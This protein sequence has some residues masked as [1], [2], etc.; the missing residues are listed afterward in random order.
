MVNYLFKP[1]GA[2]RVNVTFLL[3]KLCYGEVVQLISLDEND[4][5]TRIHVSDQVCVLSVFILFRERRIIL[6]GLETVYLYC[7]SCS[8]WYTSFLSQS[9][10]LKERRLVIGQ[11]K[12][13]IPL[14]TVA[15]NF[16]MTNGLLLWYTAF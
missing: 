3:F 10:Y 15:Y 5:G 11:S 7:I 12:R 1:D 9:E 4:N 8:E 16:L 14:I 13:C 6:I 2:L